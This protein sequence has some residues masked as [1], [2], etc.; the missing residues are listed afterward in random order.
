MGIEK[1]IIPQIVGENS[2]DTF[3]WQ[4]IDKRGATN[5]FLIS[6]GDF[7]RDKRYVL[8]QRFSF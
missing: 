6:N 4:A 5:Y 3:G 8:N 2:L 1:L 7:F